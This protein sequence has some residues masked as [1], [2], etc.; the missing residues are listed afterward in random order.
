MAMPAPIEPQIEGPPVLDD[1]PKVDAWLGLIERRGTID[2]L[3]AF[4]Y[5]SFTEMTGRAGEF[6]GL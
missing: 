3:V 2:E 6:F 4:F 5:D 1:G